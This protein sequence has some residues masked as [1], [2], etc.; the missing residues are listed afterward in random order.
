M[1][2]AVIINVSQLA[3]TLL[4]HF[5]PD[6]TFFTELL[7]LYNIFFHVNVDFHSAPFILWMCYFFLQKYR[8]VCFKSL[9]MPPLSTQ[10][11]NKWFAVFSFPHHKVL[12]SLSAMLNVSV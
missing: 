1:L 11:V 3:Q 2:L 6:M 5:G 7:Y 12:T 8:F 4:E 9:S 10:T